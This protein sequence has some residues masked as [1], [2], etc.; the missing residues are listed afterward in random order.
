[1]LYV[2]CESIGNGLSDINRFMQNLPLCDFF[3]EVNRRN[4][5]KGFQI[6][7]AQSYGRVCQPQAQLNLSHILSFNC[8]IINY[9]LMWQFVY[10]THNFIV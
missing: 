3:E 2:L 9:N 10:V 8:H 1:M 6:Q 7:L 5:R 4:K